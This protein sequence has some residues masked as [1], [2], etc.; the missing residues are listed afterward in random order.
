M[1]LP[2]K[3]GAVTQMTVIMKLRKELPRMK[4]FTMVFLYSEH[5]EESFY[6]E[7]EEAHIVLHIDKRSG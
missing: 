6:H 7:S 4:L 5:H 3:A 2:D 1:Y